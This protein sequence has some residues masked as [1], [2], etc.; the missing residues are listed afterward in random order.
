MTGC[1]QVIKNYRQCSLRVERDVRR[2]VD[3]KTRD[4]SRPNDIEPIDEGCTLRAVDI[5]YVH[6][7]SCNAGCMIGSTSGF[8]HAGNTLGIEVE[9]R[10]DVVTVDRNRR[11]RVYNAIEIHRF[12]VARVGYGV[13]RFR[14]TNLELHDCSGGRPCIRVL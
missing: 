10:M 7:L 14:R 1:A 2:F 5:A 3:E 8:T 13:L 6:I 11:V 4:S 12:P 9:C